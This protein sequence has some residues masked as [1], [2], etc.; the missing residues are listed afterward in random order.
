[1]RGSLEFV[2]DKM[3]VSKMEELIFTGLLV[4]VLLEVTAGNA[5]GLNDSIILW[6]WNNNLNLLLYMGCQNA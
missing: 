1:M 3:E 2:A 5:N 6:I 4:L